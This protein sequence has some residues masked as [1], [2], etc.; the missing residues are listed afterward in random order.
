MIFISSSFTPTMNLLLWVRY[1]IYIYMIYDDIC[2]FVGSGKIYI[3][4][5][6]SFSGCTH[7]LLLMHPKMKD[8]Y[9]PSLQQASAPQS[10][11]RA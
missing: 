10:R 5:Y 6:E 7:S 11:H 8:A 1:I 3:Y 2:M 4:I 9:L